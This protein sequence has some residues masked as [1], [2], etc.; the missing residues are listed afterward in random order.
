MRVLVFG[1]FDELHP[2][3]RFVL[4]E[5]GKYGDLAVVVARDRNVARLKGRA[6][7]ENEDRR[8]R[9]IEAAFPSAAVVRGDPD[10]FLAPVRAL[11]PDLI[12]LGYDQKLPPGVSEA[13]FPCPVRRLPAHH[14]DK[15][16]SSLLRGT[17]RKR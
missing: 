1:T 13:D 10:D 11:R 8:K 4:E 14:P 7:V 15:F 6:P 16:K 12:L 3:H 2:G 9:A 5:A 17:E